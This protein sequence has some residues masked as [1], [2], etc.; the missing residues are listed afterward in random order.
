MKK[1]LVVLFIVLALLVIVSVDVFV[2]LLYVFGI[3]FALAWILG[4]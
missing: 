1:F 4:W 2:L 3:L